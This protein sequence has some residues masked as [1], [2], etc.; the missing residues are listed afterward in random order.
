MRIFSSSLFEE[1]VISEIATR[2]HKT[3]YA[4]FL[5]GQSRGYQ[6]SFLQ[7]TLWRE[8]FTWLPSGVAW[9]SVSFSEAQNVAKD[10]T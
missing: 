5:K 2:I 8:H 6:T 4:T 7:G 1:N 3:L 9:T 10:S